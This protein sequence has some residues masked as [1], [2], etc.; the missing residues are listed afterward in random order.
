MKNRETNEN[1]DCRAERIAPF[2]FKL[3]KNITDFLST[4]VTCTLLPKMLLGSDFRDDEGVFIALIPLDVWS[5]S[6]LPDIESLSWGTAE[7]RRVQR[8][9][10]GYSSEVQCIN[11]HIDLSGLASIIEHSVQNGCLHDDDML[12]RLGEQSIR[13]MM[14]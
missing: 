9:A 10:I 7:G 2:Y 1:D 4:N 14:P 11:G 12:L 5:S 6:L 13:M 3:P 8:L